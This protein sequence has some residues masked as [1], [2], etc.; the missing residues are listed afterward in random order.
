KFEFPINQ[1]DEDGESD[2]ELPEEL[3]RLLEQ[4]S[5]EIQPNQEPVEVINL[6]TEDDVREVKIGASLEAKERK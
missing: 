3:A 4:E 5:K 1:A 6:G 2:H